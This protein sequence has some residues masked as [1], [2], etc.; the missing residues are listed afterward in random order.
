MAGHLSSGTGDYP[1]A[2]GRHGSSSRRACPARKLCPGEGNVFLL[3]TWACLGTECTKLST[4]TA[5]DESRGVLSS[6]SG[7]SSAHSSPRRAVS[8][9]PG[10]C[11]WGNGQA[12]TAILVPGQ[13]HRLAG[14]CM[15]PP[16]KKP[17]GFYHA[18]QVCEVPEASTSGPMTFRGHCGGSHSRAR[19]R[20][21]GRDC[22]QEGKREAVT[23]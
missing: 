20:W 13:A 11:R 10:A 2:L 16:D 12:T 18:P 22:V 3:K 5:K 7:V 14:T 9:H 8:L 17:H 1:R 6:L 23:A 4:S 19:K 15:R 21:G